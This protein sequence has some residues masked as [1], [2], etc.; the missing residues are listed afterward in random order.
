MGTQAWSMWPCSDKSACVYALSEDVA[1]VC[2]KY[3]THI[4]LIHT[5]RAHTVLAFMFACQGALY[6]P[7]LC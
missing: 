4:V 2:T 3:H 1:I 5:V 7:G 6:M